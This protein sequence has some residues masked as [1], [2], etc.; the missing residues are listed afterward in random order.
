NIA[1]GCGR[2]GP[3]ELARFR[4]I[5]MGSAGE[6]EYHLLLAR[7]LEVLAKADYERL[8]GDVT[9]V[10]RMLTSL[11]RKLKADGTHILQQHYRTA[12]STLVPAR[13]GWGRVTCPESGCAAGPTRVGS[14]VSAS[15]SALPVKVSATHTWRLSRRKG[16]GPP[17]QEDPSSCRFSPVSRKS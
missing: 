17:L 5:A 16:S 4:S 3:A 2:T 15:S 6:L 1:E 14:W 13:P 10:K 7:D 11:I 8:D 9:E 12:E